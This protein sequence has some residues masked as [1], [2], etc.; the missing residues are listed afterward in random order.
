MSQKSHAS[1]ANRVVS[2]V[3]VVHVIVFVILTAVPLT[4]PFIFRGS[5]NDFFS[6]FKTKR[7]VLYPGLSVF[8]ERERDRD[9]Q[10]EAERDRDAP[11]NPHHG[12]NIR[13]W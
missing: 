9:R 5:T 13:S 7:F 8:R 6:K 10:T 4:N 11:M 3:I 12:E 2:H 1:V